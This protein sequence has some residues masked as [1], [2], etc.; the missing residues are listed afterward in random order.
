MTIII[1][2]ICLEAG[3]QIATLGAIS[4]C[5]VTRGMYRQAG[6]ILRLCISERYIGSRWGNR[7]E[8]DHWGDLG[9]DGW[10]ILG[11]ICRRWDVGIWT[12]PG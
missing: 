3:F 5:G 12:G 11:R 9:V 10:I 2:I 4:L 8:R 6:I 7:R 1:I